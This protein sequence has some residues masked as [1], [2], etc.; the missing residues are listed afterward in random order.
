VPGE[1][2]RVR[3]FE[4]HETTPGYF[5][6]ASGICRVVWSFSSKKCGEA[7]EVGAGSEIFS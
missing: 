7:G 3:N 5:G 6:A 2:A 4:Y 1:T